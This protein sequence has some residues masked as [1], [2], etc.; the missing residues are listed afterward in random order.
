MSTESPTTNNYQE[1]TRVALLQQSIKHINETLIRFERRL[2]KIDEEIKETKKELKNDIRRN[3]LWTL[4]VI[5][6]VVIVLPR[7]HWF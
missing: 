4:G 6:I 2:D 5:C 3:F 7:L 1:E